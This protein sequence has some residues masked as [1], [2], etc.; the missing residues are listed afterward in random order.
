MENHL[1]EENGACK[2]ILDDIHM[3]L[4]D[5]VSKWF[6]NILMYER[7]VFN[8]VETASEA[9]VI[10]HAVWRMLL[11]VFALMLVTCRN[12]FKSSTIPPVV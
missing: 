2:S 11:S 12:T 6:Q 3:C 1:Y 5:F 7:K 4:W 10:V 9:K 8:G